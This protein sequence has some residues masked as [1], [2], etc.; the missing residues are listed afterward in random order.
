[1]LDR[2]S[3]LS[4]YEAKVR[5]VISGPRAPTRTV[6]EICGERPGGILLHSLFY[7]DTSAFIRWK[8]LF[9]ELVTLSQHE[10][11]AR[12]R[13]W[14]ARHNAEDS[15]NRSISSPLPNAISEIHKYQF[16]QYRELASDPT[17]QQDYIQIFAPTEPPSIAV[18]M[19]SPNRTDSPFHLEWL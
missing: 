16:T 4:S 11:V 7:I 14:T 18:E 8:H 10:V 5:R 15:G 13:D 17:E 3:H 1:L 2:I 12:L 9:V 6:S 19:C